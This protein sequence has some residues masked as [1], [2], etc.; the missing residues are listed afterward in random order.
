MFPQAEAHPPYV[1]RH[2]PT[3]LAAAKEDGGPWKET[4][5]R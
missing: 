2:Q 5:G 4:P 1:H 3:R